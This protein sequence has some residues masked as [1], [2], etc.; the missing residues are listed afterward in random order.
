MLELAVTQDVGQLIEGLQL[1][2][3]LPGLLFD[4]FLRLFVSEP[5]VRMDDAFAKP[6]LHDVG[7]SVHL[8]Y[9]REYEAVFLRPER[10]K[11]IREALGKHGYHAVYQ[12]NGGAALVGFLVE[13]RI[14]SDEMTHIGKM[15]AHIV[16]ANG[17]LF[18]RDGIVEVLG[19]FRVDGK[20]SYLAEVAA[21]SNFFRRYFG[22]VGF[23]ICFHCFRKCQ[24]E[25]EIG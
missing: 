22:A 18:E 10:A 24:W 1:R 8:E 12:V 9:G 15:H 25:A 3:E 21:S 5:P 11:V 19:I 6:V 4:D 13:W 23:R 7:I 14:G 20:G 2:A 17:Q 16:M